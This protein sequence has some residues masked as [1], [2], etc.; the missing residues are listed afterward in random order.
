MRPIH[1][2]SAPTVPLSTN[3]HLLKWVEKMA[4]LT[5][6]AAVHWVDGSQEEYDALCAQM[7]EGGSF[8]KLN[9]ELWPGC[10][11]ARSDPSDVARVEDRTFICSYSKEAA[12]PTNNWEDPFQM[13]RKLKELFDGADARADHVRAAVQHGTDRLSHVADRRAAHRLAL[14][15]RQHAHHG[16]HRSARLRG[17]RQRRKARRA[18]HAH[19]RRPARAGTAGRTLALQPGEVHRPLPGDAARS[20]PTAPATGATPC[21]ARS[22]SPSASPRTSRATRAG[23]P[24]TCSSSASRTR[25][26]KRPTSPPRSLPPAARRTSPC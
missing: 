7:V 10:Y 23:W 9:E 2:N 18:V 11:Y 17:D 25:A 8:I 13:R 14:R 20:G 24:S 12:G 16:P 4:R 22:A 19:R 1:D 5:Q 21:S 3:A 15:R 6:P 26:A